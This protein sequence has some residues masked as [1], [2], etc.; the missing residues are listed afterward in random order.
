VTNRIEIKV[1]EVTN[2][3]ESKAKEKKKGVQAV[4]GAAKKEKYIDR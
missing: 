1:E 2:T 4:Q 3:K